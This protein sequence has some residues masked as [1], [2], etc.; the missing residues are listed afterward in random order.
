MSY[1]LIK[2]SIIKYIELKT[3]KNYFNY[4]ELKQ[5]KILR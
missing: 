4:Y 2:K 5:K 1:N 3:Y